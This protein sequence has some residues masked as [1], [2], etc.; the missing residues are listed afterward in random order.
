MQPADLIVEAD[1]LGDE[2]RTQMKWRR[3]P[4]FFRVT[5]GGAEQRLALERREQ[6]RRML[7]PRRQQIV[8][9]AAGSNLRQPVLS[10]RESGDAGLT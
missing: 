3:D 1:H 10:E 4:R 5:S 9:V 7:E 6:S 2:G 8:A